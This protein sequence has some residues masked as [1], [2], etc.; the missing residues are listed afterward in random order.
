MSLKS[1]PLFISS[2]S[3]SLY[4]IPWICFSA[5]A[6]FFPSYCMCV[7]LYVCVNAWAY[8]HMEVW[9]HCWVLCPFS[10]IQRETGYL[11]EPELTISASL[12]HNLVPETPCSCLSCLGI[13]DWLLCSPSLTLDIG[14]QTPVSHLHCKH[15]TPWAI[16]PGPISLSWCLLWV[17]HFK[18]TLSF[19]L[20]NLVR[21]W[22]S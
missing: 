16:S 1:S 17:I 19:C 20:W 11:N 6:W 4:V 15:F 13:T 9:G 18:Y 5:S 8:M 22:W 3:R 10:T 12:A 21:G 7:Y 2:V 14:I